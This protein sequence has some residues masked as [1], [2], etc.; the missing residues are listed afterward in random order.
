MMKFHGMHRLPVLPL[1]FLLISYFGIANG[2]WAAEPDVKPGDIIGP[3]NWPKVKG[4]VGENLLNR[5]KQGYTFSIKQGRSIG[6]PRDYTAATARYF[7]EVKL[8]PS[9]ELLNY[10]AGLPFPDVRFNDPQ[11]GLKMAW[12]FYW[13]WLGDDY[14]TGGGTAEGKIIRYAI[15]RDGSERRAD[16]L[17]HTVKTRGRVTLDAKP[18]LTGYEHIDWMQLRADEYPRDTA[19]TTTLEIR[20]AD[21]K[22]D[23]DLYIYVPSIRRVRR[24]PPIQR[25]ATIAPSEFNFDDINS[26]GGKVSDFNY[27]FLGQ[28]KMLG[29][30]A[31]EQIPFYRK[32]GD[33][34]PLRESWEIV[35]TYSLEITPKDPSYCYPRKV[36]YFDTQNFEALWTMIWDA[37]GNYWKEQFA[38]RSPVKLADGQSAL[39]VG[40]VI[41]VNVQNGRSTLV[42]AVRAYN[43][44]YQP[45][46]FTLATL[47]TVM[48]G[49]AIR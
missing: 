13:R 24:A 23:D 26:F 45:S 38:L 49:G 37:K 15:E 25:C 10:V 32:R 18:V 44:G 14:R 17:H 9:G 40:S 8:G 21:P 1:W 7:T 47:Q 5:I 30:F 6:F 36:I 28:S 34:L 33:Y 4:M 16:V 42:D 12:N 46:L 43:Q 27:R 48:R 11:I 35:D 2:L 22:R 39:S 41:I 20:Y 31:Q 19:G 3:E 29:N